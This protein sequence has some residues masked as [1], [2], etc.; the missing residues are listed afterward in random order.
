MRKIPN[1]RWID[2][3]GRDDADVATEIATAIDPHPW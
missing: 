2:R 1:L 3:T